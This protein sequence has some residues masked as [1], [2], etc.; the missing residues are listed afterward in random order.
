MLSFFSLLR[1]S[2]ISHVHPASGF[3]I[4]EKSRKHY[5][6]GLSFGSSVSISTQVYVAETYSP[7]GCYG[8]VVE[9]LRGGA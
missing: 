7:A 1:S 9:S 3:N 4:T 5:M 8:K 6:G 2:P